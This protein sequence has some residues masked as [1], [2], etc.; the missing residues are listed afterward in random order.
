MAVIPIPG[1]MEELLSWL[2][3]RSPPSSYRPE[4]P[5]H[6]QRVVGPAGFEPETFRKEVAEAI[7]RCLWWMKKKNY[8]ESTI[9][10]TSQRL[11][12]LA[13]NVDI[14]KPEQVEEYVMTRDGWSTVYKLG[15][16]VAYYRFAQANGIKYRPPKLRI[17]PRPIQVPSEEDIGLIISSCRFKNCVQFTILKETGLRPIELYNLRL[18]D[19]DLKQGLIY[20]RTAKYGANRVIKLRPHI[21]ELLERYIREIQRER[22]LTLNSRLFS[23]PLTLKKAWER[24]RKRTAKKFGKPELLKIRLYDLRH[25]YATKLYKK[26]KDIMYVK[27]ALGHK[28][29]HHVIKYIHVSEAVEEEYICKVAKTPEEVKELIEAGFEYVCEKDGV[30]FF[31]KLKI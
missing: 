2:L 8:A 5:P 7:F 24:A 22:E 18:R 29:L 16:L 30:M 12:Y 9:I 6:A 1:R 14:F 19:I 21:R 15:V 28:T 17:Q 25:F 26:T 31:R 10:G 13:K 4:L 11:R 20:V 23:S 27:E 3:P